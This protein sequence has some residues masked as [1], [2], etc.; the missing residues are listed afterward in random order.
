MSQN[1]GL[2]FAENDAEQVTLTIMALRFRSTLSLH[3]IAMVASGVQDCSFNHA[4]QHAIKLRT[5]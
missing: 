4:L 2:D 1:F 3:C 5:K